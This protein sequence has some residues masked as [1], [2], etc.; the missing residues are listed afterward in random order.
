M[1][2]YFY[3]CAP[4][5]ILFHTQI[6]ILDTS[7]IMLTVFC[8]SMIATSC[9]QRVLW[10]IFKW[11]WMWHHMLF[12]VL[13]RNGGTQVYDIYRGGGQHVGNLVFIYYALIKTVNVTEIYQCCVISMHVP[14][15]HLLLHGLLRLHKSLMFEGKCHLFNYIPTL[16]VFHYQR[17]SSIIGNPSC[18][19]VSLKWVQL[20][21]VPT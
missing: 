4:P 19:K 18:A 11:T 17:C 6:W 20:P 16:V 3:A 9:W 12:P 10:A 13:K 2:C 14:P 8:H 5:Q 1:L 21:S 7:I 15:P